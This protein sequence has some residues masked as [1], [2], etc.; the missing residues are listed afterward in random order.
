MME[1]N[2][3]VAAATE[4]G[5]KTAVVVRPGNAPLTAEEEGAYKTV[6]DFERV[7]RCLIDIPSK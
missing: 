6:Q 7:T 4:A 2:L 3:E 5:M 1:R